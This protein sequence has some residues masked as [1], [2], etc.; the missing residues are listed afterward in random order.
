MID[1]ALYQFYAEHRGKVSDKWSIYLREYDR[2]FADYRNKSIDLLE[3]GIQNGGSLD[4]WGHY[5]PHAQKIIGCDIN[6]DCAKLVYGDQRISVIIGDANS[7]STFSAIKQISSDFD[8]IIDDGSHQS[9]DIVKSFALYFPQLRDGGLFVAEDLHCSY[10]K[11][12][13]GGLFS[14]FSSI[15]F[16]KRLA[17]IINHEHWGLDIAR[18]ELLTG[19][20]SQYGLVIDEV[21]LA[22]IHSIEFINSICVI[23]KS[24]ADQNILGTRFIAGTLALAEAEPASLHGTVAATPTQLYSSRSGPIIPP[25]EEHG[26]LIKELDATQQKLSKQEIL[27]SSDIQRLNQEIIEKDQAFTHEIAT[28]NQLIIEKDQAFTHEIATLNQLIIEKDQAFTHEITF[29]K[30]LIIEKNSEVSDLK[31]TIIEKD[32]S[33]HSEI[34]QLKFAIQA[35]ENLIAMLYHSTSWRITLPLRMIKI[36]LERFFKSSH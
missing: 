7:S 17:D 1:N 6:P 11:E 33:H 3:I 12:F 29:L 26:Y 32:I 18:A 36:F 21:T 15:A 9:G 23:R 35:K 16:F 2:L 13:E 31:D 28:L 22:S 20:F 24:P 25:D 8:L 34:E 27:Y 4:I 30:Q 5:F 10:W 14:P 19:F